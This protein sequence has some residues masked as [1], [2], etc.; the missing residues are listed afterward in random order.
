MKD[1]L[2]YSILQVQ[3]KVLKCGG[4]EEHDSGGF[5]FIF[6]FGCGLNNFEYKWFGARKFIGHFKRLLWGQIKAESCNIQ[7][8][9][10]VDRD[11]LFV[12]LAKYF[13]SFL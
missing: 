10:L 6:Y 9:I 3:G 7:D 11:R 12:V 4:E 13:N 5:E 1:F 8:S 2:V